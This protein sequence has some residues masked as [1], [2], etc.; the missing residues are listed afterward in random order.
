[1]AQW[2]RPEP[3]IGAERTGRSTIRL[4]C[5]VLLVALLAIA[6]V[7]CGGR[8]TPPGAQKALGT[9]DQGGY[10]FL[11]L[12]EG[13][14]VLLWHDLAGEAAARSTGFPSGHFYI[15]R[16]SARAAGGTSLTWE[17]QTTDGRLGE[18]QIGGVRYDLAAGTLFLVTT[19]GGAT[20]VTQLSRDLSAV[21]LDHN[22]ILAFARKDP[23]LAAFLDEM[24]PGTRP[25]TTPAPQ[26]PTMAA[27]DASL[28]PTPT[29][30][31]ASPPTAVQRTCFC[32]AG[33]K[34]AV[35]SCQQVLGGKQ[36]GDS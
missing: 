15:E 6:V 34:S 13:L 18:A 11:R 5:P 33:S 31:T 22:G 17:V 25:G 24:P 9:C 7:A 14:Q 8:S 4:T 1:M 10:L 3:E 27:P 19:R 21:P 30:C 29:R 16:G 26:R 35:R 36:Y 23:D 28:A 12:Q 20:K 2:N 32:C